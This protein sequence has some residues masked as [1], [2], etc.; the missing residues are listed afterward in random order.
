MVAVLRDTRS[1][2]TL[3]T[4]RSLS[5]LL[6]SSSIIACDLPVG[7]SAD[8]FTIATINPRIRYSEEVETSAGNE[9]KNVL[10]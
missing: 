9:G 3:A 4:D 8:G 6:P 10:F 7:E 2:A 5:P 1:R